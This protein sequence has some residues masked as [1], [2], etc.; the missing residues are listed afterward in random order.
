MTRNLVPQKGDSWELSEFESSRKQST[1][2]GT[3]WRLVGWWLADSGAGA[4]RRLIGLTVSSPGGWLRVGRLHTHKPEPNRLECRRVTKFHIIVQSL[5]E[6][7]NTR[8]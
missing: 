2:E 3:G 5:L 1:E 6:L 8:A 7:P 4:G